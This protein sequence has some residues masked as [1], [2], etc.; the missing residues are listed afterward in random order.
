MAAQTAPFLS[1]IVSQDRITLA[2][3]HFVDSDL[4]VDVLGDIDPPAGALDGSQ[5]AN[6]QTLGQAIGAFLSQKQI[7]ARDVAVVLPEGNAVTQL[8]KLPAMPAEDMAGA[9]RSVAER[10]AIFAEH[11]I[12]VDC[13]TIEEFEEDGNTMANV[14]FAAARSSN[15]EQCLECARAA[16]L[17]LISVEAAPVAAANAYRDRLTRQGDV[18]A[19]AVVGETRTDVMIFDRGTLRLCYSANAGLPEQT[20]QG[21][22]MTPPPSDYD[23]FTPPPQLYSELNHCFRFF[24]NQFPRSAVQRVVLA[25][26]HAKA[27][28]IASHLAEQLQL[29]VELGRLGS[30][31]LLPGGVDAEAA[32]TS[33]SLTL[34]LLR[35]SAL[36][37]LREAELLFPIN[38]L[39]ASSTM[40]RPVRP[41]I[42]LGFA[43][44]ALLLIA[45]IAW[46]WS[47]S[48]KTKMNERDLVAC[49][50]Q[51]ARLQPD[52]DAL[53]AARATELALYTEVERQTAR[54]ARE[55]SVHWSQILVDVSER[56]PHDMWLSRLASPDST[57]ITLTG[58]ST[59]RETIPNA[60][61]SLGG[62][63]Y[64]SDVR[65]S[66]LTKDDAYAP[67]AVV[68]RYQINGTLLRGIQPPPMAAL[69]PGAETQPAAGGQ[70]APQ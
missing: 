7:G 47:L 14:L 29:P 4:H 53:R 57:K 59:N 54:I 21:D 18:V 52:L 60:I 5:I 28:L 34:A 43:G 30:D 46:A 42:K 2:E 16:G 61:Q 1:I 70:E 22:W 32:V 9:V 3:A 39:P 15:V 13:S 69:A 40:W 63:P 26:D 31:L 35:G 25:A 49:Q 27:D 36:S 44:I 12:N 51:I 41:Y 10:Y 23:P 17:E 38:L 20:D 68:I 58:I 33:R 45:A 65:L 19:L 6:G 37:V 64:L 56:L 55:R 8:I 24:Q 48:N 50:N 62:S 66:S 67:G 11:A